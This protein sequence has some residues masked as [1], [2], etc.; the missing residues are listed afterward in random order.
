MLTI[1]I[2]RLDL[3]LGD[4]VLDLGCGDG[5]HTR[6]LR[7][8]EGVTSVAL[9]LG[10]EEVERTHGTLTFMD[11]LKPEEGGPAPPPPLLQ[12]NKTPS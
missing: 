11:A 3:R 2:E 10:R 1:E 12:E 8:L 6:Y 7:L 9:D 5:R 4:R